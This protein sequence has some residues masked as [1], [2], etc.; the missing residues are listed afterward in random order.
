MAN[1]YM[2]NPEKPGVVYPMKADKKKAIRDGFTGLNNNG[3]SCPKCGRKMSKRKQICKCGYTKPA[4]PSQAKYRWLALFVAIF[5]V[6]AIAVIPYT[7]IASKTFDYELGSWVIAT[8]KA[9][10]LSMITGIMDAKIF[11]SLPAFEI[12]HGGE[13]GFMYSIMTYAFLI[14]AVLAAIQAVFALLSYDKAAK[15]VRRALFLLGIG[16]LVYTFGFAGCLNTIST[17]VEPVVAVTEGVLALGAYSLEMMSVLV[18]AVALVL[19][20]V[21]RICSNRILRLEKKIKKAQAKI[22]KAK[23]L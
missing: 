14:I 23:G 15:R 17:D 4:M 9:S 3:K 22:N 13:S 16:A 8:E 6:L 20:L 21:V 11:G 18:G 19:S 2:Y 10:A 5:A 1:Y 7:V 12:A